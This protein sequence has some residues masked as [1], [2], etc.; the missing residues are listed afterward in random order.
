MDLIVL[1]KEV[2][3][4]HNFKLNFLPLE[5]GVPRSGEGFE[6]LNI[7]SNPRECYV[8]SHSLPLF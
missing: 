4:L 8:R 2:S 3:Y 1:Q 7:I 6:K 5:K